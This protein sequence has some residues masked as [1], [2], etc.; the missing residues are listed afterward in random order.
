[1]FPPHRLPQLIAFR[2][3]VDPARSVVERRIRIEHGDQQRTAALDTDASRFGH[4]DGH[5]A[6][7]FREMRISRTRTPHLQQ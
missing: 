7:G 3:I 5:S 4:N 6:H 2:R 1:M